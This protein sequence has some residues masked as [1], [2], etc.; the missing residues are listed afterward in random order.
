MAEQTLKITGMDCM[1][2]AK[3]LQAA[4]AALPQVEA[5]EVRFF[6][7]TLTVQGDVDPDELHKLIT[8]LGVWGG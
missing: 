8:K 7:G 3:A 4:V 2:C 6:E 5:A 1:D